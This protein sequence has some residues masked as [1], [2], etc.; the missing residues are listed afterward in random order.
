MFRFDRD[1]LLLAVLTAAAAMVGLLVVGIAVFL[2]WEAAPA[3]ADVGPRFVTD[4]SWHPAARAAAGT[5]QILPIA[6][7]TI[8][9]SAGAILLAAPLGVL[10]AIWCRFYAAGWAASGM[11]HLTALAAGIPSV[12]YGLWGLTALV[13]LLGRLAPPG[14][15]LL[16]GAVVLGL[17]IL[18]TVALLSDAALGQ[19][20]PHALRS[21]AALGL[22]RRTTICRIV[23]PMTRR[24]LAGAILLGLAR[25][26]GETMAVLMVCGNVV[27]VP[28]GPLDPVRT[29]TATIALEL[30]YARGTHRAALFACGLVLLVVVV[31]L[32]AGTESLQ[33]RRSHVA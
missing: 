10:T 13:P 21:A 28:R 25:A 6:L 14:T 22:S 2:V 8:L 3:L 5:F 11:R 20:S 17:M 24:M 23:L 31:I 16:A 30:G 12:V 7:G 18:P 29:L 19:V 27:A 4:D 9:V 15:S 26:I 1:R 32:I 33:R